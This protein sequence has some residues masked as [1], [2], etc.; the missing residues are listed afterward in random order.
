MN[1]L[2]EVLTQEQQALL[3][4]EEDVCFYEE[5]GWYISPPVISEAVIDQAIAG[6][7]DFYDGVQDAV[8]PVATGY[9]N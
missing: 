4:T 9:S 6:S 5:H 2:E 1:I 3:P 8:L 7:Q